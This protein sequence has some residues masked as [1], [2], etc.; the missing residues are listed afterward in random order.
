M[1]V[2]LSSLCGGNPKHAVTTDKDKYKD[3][4]G[5][6][7]NGKADI[8]EDELFDDSVPM[9]E[10]MMIEKGNPSRIY[11]FM[12]YISHNRLYLSHNYESVCQ[13]MCKFYSGNS[14]PIARSRNWAATAAARNAAMTELALVNIAGSRRRLRMQTRRRR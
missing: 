11:F 13:S 6:K 9:P 3:K 12:K 14:T 8:D 2:V 10:S 7:D 4:D 5:D 1:V